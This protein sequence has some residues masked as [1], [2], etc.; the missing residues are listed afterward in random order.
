MEMCESQATS[1]LSTRLDRRGNGIQER[2][3]VCL[4]LPLTCRKER[5]WCIVSIWLRD[6][7]MW[8]SIRRV[9]RFT[10]KQRQWTWSSQSTRDANISSAAISFHGRTIYDSE[11]LRGQMLDLLQRPYTEMRVKIF[12]GVCRRITRARGYYDVKVE[13][14]GAP[15]DAVNGRVPVHVTITAGP[16][17][18]FDGVTVTGLDRL[19]PSYVIKRFTKL[20]GKAIA[21]TCWTSDFARLMQYWPF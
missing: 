6:F 19:R 21:R 13:A 14:S 3:K 9:I 4:L 5:T 1:S 18:Y 7:W 11:T 17:Y 12:R 20:E 16:V 10:G 2:R 8:W 15:E